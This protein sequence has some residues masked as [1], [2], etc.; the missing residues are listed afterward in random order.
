MSTRLD[1]S[2]LHRA[3]SE[4]GV[5]IRKEDEL[6]PA[7]LR[8]IEQWKRTADADARKAKSDTAAALTAYVRACDFSPES[9]RLMILVMAATRGEDRLTCAPDWMMGA[10]LKGLDATEVEALRL[11][12]TR[13]REKRN[14]AQNWKRAW[15]GFDLEQ[16]RIGIIAI[17]RLPGRMDQKTGKGRASELYALFVQDLVEIEREAK[18]M[19]GGK[20]Y[21]RFDRA[22]RVIAEQ[23]R[24]KR[25]HPP[26]IEAEPRRT[27][28]RAPETRATRLNRCVHAVHEKIAELV[29]LELAEGATPDDLHALAEILLAAVGEAVAESVPSLQADDLTLIQGSSNSPNQVAESAELVPPTFEAVCENAEEKR[30]TAPFEVLKF[31]DSNDSPPNDA[32]APIIPQFAEIPQTEPDETFAPLVQKPENEERATGCPFDAD[33][34]PAEL[35]YEPDDMELAERA[36]VQAEALGIEF[37]DE[38]EITRIPATIDDATYW[39]SWLALRAGEPYDR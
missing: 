13:D 18:T 34:P 15:D 24:S 14:L 11:L 38:G 12:P 8:S 10:Y 29:K 32:D 3:V 17:K 35:T 1:H 6:E 7:R 30:E 5:K 31:E 16:K 27:R 21:E 33:E 37:D 2:Y 22:A 23:E 19:R 25:P 36:A 9:E 26:D 39:Q 28:L 20:R 4:L